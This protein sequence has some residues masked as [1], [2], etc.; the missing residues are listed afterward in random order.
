[1]VT[2]HPTDQILEVLAP[3]RPDLSELLSSRD[4]TSKNEFRVLCAGPIQSNQLRLRH[5]NLP[6]A[7]EKF[8]KHDLLRIYFSIQSPPRLSV[9]SS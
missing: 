6:G 2:G 8:L 1:M 5:A 9:Q 3:P 4:V 7:F